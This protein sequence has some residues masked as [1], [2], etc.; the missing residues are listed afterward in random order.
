[1]SWK[2]LVED[3]KQRQL[4]SIPKDWFIDPP[5]TSQLDVTPIPAQCGLL[6]QRELEITDTTDVETLL[7]KLANGEWSSFEVTTAFY[8]RAIVAHQLVGCIVRVSPEDTN[9]TTCV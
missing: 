3:K 4:A 6:S 1:M 8:K 5:P 7:K 2:T 9:L